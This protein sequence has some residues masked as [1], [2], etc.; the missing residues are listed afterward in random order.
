MSDAEDKRTGWSIELA[1]WLD[2]LGVLQGPCT[3]DRQT[4][5]VHLPLHLPIS[6]QIATVTGEEI[7]RVRVGTMILGHSIILIWSMVLQHRT[8]ADQHDMK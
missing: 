6:E 5:S 7:P 2:T 3:F 4:E 1:G 8:Q